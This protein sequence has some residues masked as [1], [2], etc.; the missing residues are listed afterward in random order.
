[1]WYDFDYVRLMSYTKK[2][3]KA[4][5]QDNVAFWDLDNYLLIHPDLLNNT[6]IFRTEHVAQNARARDRH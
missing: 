5:V 6:K 2:S 3:R 4:H 1:M